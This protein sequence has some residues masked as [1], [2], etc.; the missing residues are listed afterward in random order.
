MNVT[1][2]ASEP[3]KFDFG[4]ITG[5][6]DLLSTTGAKAQGWYG[7]RPVTAGV[8]SA[9]PLI[10]GVFTTKPAPAGTADLSM[11]ANTKAFD[12]SITSPVSDLWQQSAKV[13][14]TNLSLFT[15]QPGQ[16]REI[17]VT[18]TPT[19]TKGTVVRGT[20]FVDDFIVGD[21]PAW[22]A[23]NFALPSDFPTSLPF[24]ANGS[25]LASFP[26]EYKIK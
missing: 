14:N 21:T 7:N 13:T 17:P 5:D 6:P 18:I 20:A 16:T 8:W 10:A 12:S 22:N 25:E 26:Y 3:V 9:N 23:E 24:V 15:V 1:A 19:G 11:T 4:P 2:S